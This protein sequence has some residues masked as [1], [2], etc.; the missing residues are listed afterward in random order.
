MSN[1]NAIAKIDAS[2]I[3]S[4]NSDEIR[5]FADEI[6]NAACI[7]EEADAALDVLFASMNHYNTAYSDYT[8]IQLSVK[9][10]LNQLKSHA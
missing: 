6:E 4:L 5:A 2:S 7:Y 8:R 3:M 10:R 9:N 1:S